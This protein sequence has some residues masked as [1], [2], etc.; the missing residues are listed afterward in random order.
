MSNLHVSYRNP[1]NH[2]K[3]STNKQYQQYRIFEMNGYGNLSLLQPDLEGCGS[4]SST[5]GVQEGSE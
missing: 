2:W 5:P 1:T 3:D 4:L